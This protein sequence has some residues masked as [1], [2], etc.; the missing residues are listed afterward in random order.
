VGRPALSIHLARSSYKLDTHWPPQFLRRDTNVIVY[1]NFKLLRDKLLSK[2]NRI[3]LP[4]RQF[5]GLLITLVILFFT[6]GSSRGDVQ[7]LAILNPAMIICCGTAL[8]TIRR[9]HWAERKW[10]GGAVGLVFVLVLI[11]IASPPV[12]LGVYSRGLA[13]AANVRAAANVSGAS[14]TLGMLPLVGFQSVFFLFAPLAVILFAVQL[15]R[16]DLQLVLPVLIVLGAISGIVGVLQLAGSTSGSLYFYDITNNGSAV[17][18]FAN[19]NHASVFLACL[20][21]MLAIFASRSHATHRGGRN[22]R[23][24]MAATIAIVLIPLIL[25]TGSRSGMLAA[26]IGLIGGLILYVPRGQAHRG[27]KIGI[28]S[29]LMLASALVAC[30]VFATVYFSRAEAIE[31][32]FAE[33]GTANDRTDLWIS[34]ATLFWQYFPFGF[35]P[36]SFV[37]AFQADEPVAL[38]SDTYLNRLHNDWLETGLTYGAPGMLLMLGG[39]CYY[40]WRCFHLWFRQDGTRT[41]VALGRMASVVIAILAVASLSDYPLR[42]PAMIGFAILVSLWFIGALPERRSALETAG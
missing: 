2:C 21:P 17:G 27:P 26:I 18:L 20:F 31:R 3:A 13:N 14:E 19:R 1:F 8:L 42:T 12:H 22:R 7:S 28:P 36:G 15:G 34:G 16:E 35:G 24:L 29:M 40:F 41:S 11:Y 32:I 6:G 38:L 5:W 30:L 25:V 37:P 23:Q 4:S 10:L 33:N 39:V 9:E